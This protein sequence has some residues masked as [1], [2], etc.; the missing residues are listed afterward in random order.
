MKVEFTADAALD[1][2]SVVIDCTPKGFGHENKK[3]Y[4]EHH[5]NKTLG[6]IAQGSEYG[7]GKPYAR[8]IN[9]EI[10]VPGEDRFIQ[11]VSCNTH[12][13]ST[14]VKT[15]AL[16]DGNDNLLEGRFN[17]IRRANDLSQSTNFVPSPQVGKHGD[18][19]FGTHHARDAYLLFDTM[20]IKL[21]IFSLL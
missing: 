15:L 16:S 20:N 17:L 5:L 3:K 7:F 10:L 2:A 12:N 9:D 1:R 4:Y 13:L 21:N 18:E 8:G 14:I 19:V 6:F 11:V